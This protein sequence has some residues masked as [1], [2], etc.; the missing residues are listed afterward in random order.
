LRRLILLADDARRAVKQQRVKIA[1][2]DCYGSWEGFVS[3]M[4]DKCDNQ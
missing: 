4:A 1:I 3:A 2:K